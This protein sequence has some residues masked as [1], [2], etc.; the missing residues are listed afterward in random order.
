MRGYVFIDEVLL[1]EARHV[2]GTKATKDTMEGALRYA[3]RSRHLEEMRR[4]LGKVELDLTPEELS[5]LRAEI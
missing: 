2:L 3:I 5:R 1:K 4:S